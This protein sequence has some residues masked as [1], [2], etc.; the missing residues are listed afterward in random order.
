PLPSVCP[1]CAPACAGKQCGPDSCGG[2]CGDCLESGLGNACPDG[3]CAWADPPDCTGRVCGDDGMG[4]ACG[5]CPAGW[6]CSPQGRCES[7]TGDCGGVPATG[8][9]LSGRSVYCQAG[10]LNHE[11]CMFGACVLDPL[12]QKASCEEAPCLPRCFGRTCG[13]DGCGG[14]CG[15][16]AAGERCQAE[17]GVC[18]PESGCGGLG[19][20]GACR[21]EVLV[22]C[23]DG[24]P[25]TEACLPLGK[26]CV[27]A[28][29]GTR[30]GCCMP[31]ADEPCGALSD[32]GQCEKDYLLT[33][34][35]GVLAFQNCEWSWYARCVRTGLQSHGCGV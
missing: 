21:G 28:T 32:H 5:E 19:D 2:A 9:C 14:T 1:R 4:G 26:V 18:L 25:R 35:H 3:I 16:C 33:C 6:S 10:V 22:T 31:R 17:L 15:D 29:P 8:L 27:P 30:A 34:R 20:E 11:A 12:S 7:V 13:D 23:E 24:R